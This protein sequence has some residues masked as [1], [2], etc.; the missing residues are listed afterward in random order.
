M[1]GEVGDVSE[2]ATLRR[3]GPGAPVTEVGKHHRKTMVF[4]RGTVIGNLGR[5]DAFGGALLFALQSGTVFTRRND[6]FSHYNC[7][8]SYVESSQD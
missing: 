7:L 8:A 3:S 2:G 1:G 6:G 4:Q 5:V